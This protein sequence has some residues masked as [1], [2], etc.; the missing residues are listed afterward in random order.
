MHVCCGPCATYPLSILVKENIEI[1]GLF[2][3]PN[4]HPIEEYSKRLENAKILFENTNLNLN[5]IDDFKQEVWENYNLD[6]LSRCNMCY[7]LRFDR[8]AKYAKEKGFDAFTTSLLVSPYQK[9][10]L[11][12]EICNKVALKYGIDFYYQDFRPG[13]REGQNMAREMNLYRQKYCGCILS[14]NDAKKN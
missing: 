2:Y 10:D 14:L 9:H 1:E 8:V 4:I 6:E 13:F 11:I 7:S 12:I 5:V 3:N